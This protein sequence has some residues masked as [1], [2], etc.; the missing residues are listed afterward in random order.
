[1]KTKL[2]ELVDVERRGEEITITRNGKPVA[3]L[4][5]K[6]AYD[7]RKETVEILAD[8][9]LMQ[10]IREG[11]QALKLPPHLRDLIRQ[12]HPDLKKVRAALTDILQALACDKP[13][14]EELMGY[15]SLR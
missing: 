5:S 9:E 11:V 6:D 3:I 7:A 12:L 10:E 2:S 15:A 14:K 1:V 4:I 13:F 8:A